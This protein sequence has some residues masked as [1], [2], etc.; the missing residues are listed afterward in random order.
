MFSLLPVLAAESAAPQ[1]PLGSSLMMI[2][3]IFLVFYFILIRPQ[4][5]EKQRH[6]EK[7]A[8]L[9]KGDKIVTTGGLFGT[10]VSIKEKEGQAVIRISEVKGEPVKIEISQGAIATVLEEEPK[11]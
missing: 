2:G 3:A 10:I 8:R 4:Q 5:K 1:N 6:Q 9:K 7:I 11:Q